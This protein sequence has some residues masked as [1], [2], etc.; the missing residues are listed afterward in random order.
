M[1]KS[2]CSCDLHVRI[3]LSVEEN[4]S[5]ASDFCYE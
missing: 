3:I 1:F 5:L 2:F 4:I